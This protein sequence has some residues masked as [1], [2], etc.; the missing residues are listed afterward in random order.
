[1]AFKSNLGRQR[2]LFASCRTVNQIIRQGLF[3]GCIPKSVAEADRVTWASGSLTVQTALTG[4]SAGGG[5][6][7]PELAG[8]PSDVGQVYP[9]KVEVR[10]TAYRRWPKHPKPPGVEE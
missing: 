4:K 2:S 1:M 6:V 8:W 9:P 5:P 10:K 3:C 7:P